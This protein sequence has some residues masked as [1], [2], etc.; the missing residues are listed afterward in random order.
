[1]SIDDS[2]PTDEEIIAALSELT[3]F[4]YDRQRIGKAKK[5]GIQ[6]KTLD[7][8]VAERRP[9]KELKDGSGQPVKFDDVTPFDG[10]VIGCEVLDEA[11][12]HL[13]RHMHMDYH[14]AVCCA[15]WVAHTYMFKRFSHTPRVVISAPEPQCG[16]TV[17]LHHL[18]GSMVNKR[19]TADN[20]SPPVFFRIVETH[21]PTFMIDEVDAWLK[22]D[23]DLI[24]SLNSGFEPQGQV[25]RCVGDDHEVRGFS[26]HAPVAMS[27]IQIE[28]KLPS[29]TLDRAI[30][31][32]LERAQG[33]IS[34][35]DAFK[36]KHHASAI[37]I[38]GSK[39][40]KWMTDVEEQI[41]ATNPTMPDALINRGEDKW[42]PL[43]AIAEVAGSSW[44]ER[45]RAAF[46]ASIKVAPPTK[47]ELFLMDLAK[48][49]PPKGD[50]YT[51]TLIDKLCELDDSRYIE[52][53]F[54]AFETNK[55]T[56]KAHHLT[57]LPPR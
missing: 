26:T 46:F 31:V 57:T 22:E 17:L 30:L 32:T 3:P 34:K 25:L 16:K 6:V 11:L 24:S 15:L 50:I 29:A 20:I 39:I 23:T 33:D 38:T 5:L 9:D 14:E 48:V 19:L 1:V 8:A 44:P 40:A 21:K 53:N 35:T 4:E 56:S 51:T 13:T 55:T 42:S 45:I 2:E 10:D 12:N 49:V 36:T 18:L 41:A 27:G 54:K 28:T 52:Y 43:F 37:K 47:S 7:A